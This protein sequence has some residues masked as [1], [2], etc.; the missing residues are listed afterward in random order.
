MNLPLLSIS[1][2]R[3]REPPVPVSD[4]IVAPTA[5]V[6]V[7]FVTFKTAPYDDVESVNTIKP[8]FV[9]PF[10]TVRFEVPEAPSPCSRSVA[11]AAFVRKTL[12]ARKT[13]DPSGP[14]FI[15]RELIGLDRT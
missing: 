14:R 9:K 4:R 2:L 5:F 7:P 10:A 3:V 6:S 1:A 11:P 13:G 12:V 8:S 15:K